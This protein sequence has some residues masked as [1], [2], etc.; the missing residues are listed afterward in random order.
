M[1][2]EIEAKDVFGEIR[3]RGERAWH[4]LGVEIPTAQTTW[5]AFEQI[6]LGWETELLPVFAA[7]KG[8]D[9]KKKQ[10]K[11]NDHLLHVRKDTRD[12]LGLVGA[13]YKPISNKELADFGDA[14]VAVD[15]NVEV[16]T[17]GS[18]RNG[19]CIFALV[20][21]PH[22]IEV[23]N[24]DILQQYV[25]IRNSHDGSTAFQVYPTS[26]RVVCA[27]T[28]RLSEGSAS[29]G[30]S[31]QHTGNVANKIEHARL[32]LGLITDKTKRF[33]AQVRVMAAKHL[34][35]DEVRDYFCSVYDA[36]WGIVPEQAESDDTSAV[37]R[38]RRQI[39]KRDD[40]IARWNKNMDDAKQSMDGIRGSAWAAYN[41]VSQWHDHERGRYKPV[42]ES[43]GRAHSNLFGVADSHKKIAFNRALNLV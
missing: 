35:K 16:E 41:S 1:S 6:G 23:T 17:A 37:K 32:A 12:Q 13:G 36:T 40:M 33:E 5:N 15:K 25:L 2:H 19:R 18:L 30:I 20:R 38:F 21:L 11:L 9:G 8:E 26:V 7:Y 29:R 27:N 24:E 43:A 34:K 22:N 28:L 3:E 14:L 42:A 10:M 39:E 31:F 4:G